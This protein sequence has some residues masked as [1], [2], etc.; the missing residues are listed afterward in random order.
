MTGRPTAGHGGGP[1][2]S[3]PPAILIVLRSLEVGGSQRQAFL[4]AR[5][6]HA[7][8]GA[9][10]AVWTLERGGALAAELAAAGI[11]C[12][13][14]P[15]LSGRRGLGKIPALLALTVAIRRWRPD[16]ILSFNDFPN[17]VC[18]AVWPW[19][20]AKVC[21]WNQ[22]DEGREVTGR[23][24]ERQALRR[25]RV[26]TANSSQGADFLQ[27]RFGI[28]GSRIHLVP[29][30]VQLAP[31]KRTREQWRAALELTEQAL[32]VTM[33]ANLHRYKDHR[34]LLEA[35]AQV[36]AQSR[37]DAH[38]VLAGR[39][40]DTAEPLQDLCRRC[41]LEASVHFIGLTDDVAGLLAASDISAFSSRLEGM[42]NAV[43]ESMAAGL[44]VVATRIA[45][46]EEA[47]G[48]DYPLLVP[49]GDAQALAGALGALIDDGALRRRL[50]QRNQERARS[51][52]SV[53]R[54]GQRYTDL[55]LGYLPSSHERR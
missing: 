48:A 7:S 32:V 13:N 34:T 19:T 18:G 27:K 6:L 2:K 47:L 37:G 16:A 29:N 42:P 30:G 9:R 23:L 52:F 40:G 24:L 36:K 26:F 33:V 55:L 14:R 1:G 28:P 15:A 39:S 51:E 50:G 35:W 46:S 45:G 53:A 41:H 3:K 38:L 25:V 54:L 10:V 8:H 49:A 44:P 22:R 5:E 20:G 11:S 4:L 31:P 21:V 17:K 43:L 12:E